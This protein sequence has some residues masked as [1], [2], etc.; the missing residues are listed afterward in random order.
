MRLARAGETLMALDGK[1]YA[2]DPEITVI[3]DARGP[4]GI[5]GVHRRRG[6][7]AAA[8]TPRRSSSRWR[9]SIRVRTAAT[10][11]KLG[12]ESD[13][14]YRF[15]RGIDPDLGG[16][17]HGGRDAADPGDSAAARRARW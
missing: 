17:G 5:G 9:C 13:A 11:R 6:H 1:S 10:G 12:I 15:E 2:L 8:T 14:R 4:Q 7:Q 16:S 3:A